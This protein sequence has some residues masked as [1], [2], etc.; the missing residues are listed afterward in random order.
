MSEVERSSTGSSESW[1]RSDTPRPELPEAKASST[2]SHGT[3]T[4]SGS[5]KRR[6]SLQGLGPSKTM[7][8]KSGPYYVLPGPDESSGSGRSEQ[9]GS[10]SST[11]EIEEKKIAFSRLLKQTM[12][13]RGVTTRQLS[14]MTG[15]SEHSIN[16]YR[17]TS[18]QQLPLPPT[19]AALADALLENRLRSL[20][21][22]R[23]NCET[24]SVEFEAQSKKRDS[25]RFCSE[26]CQRAARARREHVATNQR[27]SAQVRLLESQRD[28]VTLAVRE[29]CNSCALGTQVCPDSA[30]PLACITH[31]PKE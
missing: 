18:N 17:S 10:A 3:S 6:V 23:K 8:V 30:C 28:E 27:L 13:T 4:T 15:V 29:F 22:V 21:S 5:S 24:C 20:A 14:L 1:K 7:S 25:N 9:A 12:K 19:A 26:K 11:S 31:L 16:R 2:S